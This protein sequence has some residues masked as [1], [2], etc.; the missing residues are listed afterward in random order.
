MLIRSAVAGALLLAL[1]GSA[2]AQVAGTDEAAGYIVFPKVVVD[3][4][5]QLGARTRAPTH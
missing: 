3:S 2:G 4:S 5:G 1:G